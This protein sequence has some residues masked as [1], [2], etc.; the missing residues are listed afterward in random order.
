MKRL[1]EPM[2]TADIKFLDMC[3]EIDR[4]KNEAAYYKEKYEEELQRNVEASNRSMQ[5]AKQGVA[6]ALMLSLNIK[7]GDGGSLVIDS[8][9]REALK[10]YHENKTEVA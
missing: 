6:D 5:I 8:A 9:A 2:R 10:T 3:E 1:D 7:E 4:W